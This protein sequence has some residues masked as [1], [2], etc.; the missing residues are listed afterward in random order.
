M[1]I[2][3]VGG[4]PYIT[5]S[6]I[7]NGKRLDLDLVILDTGSGGC[8]FSANELL[9]LDIAVEPM[10]RLYKIAGVGGREFVFSRRLEG[11]AVGDM[12]VRGFEVQVGAMNYGFPV[13]GII[14]L[15]FLLQVRAMIDLN[16]LE[17]S[18]QAL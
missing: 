14:G 15:D 18:A 16:R 1:N 4:T 11:V 5:A 6:L 7:H 12:E 9:H 13:Q 17:L 8:I 3:V 10:D 2:R